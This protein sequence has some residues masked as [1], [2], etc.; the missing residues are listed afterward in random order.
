MRRARI[1]GSQTLQTTPHRRR[2][3][4]VMTAKT[5][6][7]VLGMHR[8]G[9]SSVAGALVL[10][11]GAPPKHLMPA[12]ADNPKGFWESSAIA[13]FNDRLL[14]LES[15]N[16]HD[17]RSIGGA[18]IKDKPHLLHEGVDLLGQEFGDA[19]TIV[20]KDP[21]ICRLFPFWRGLLEQAGYAIVI[22]SPVRPPWE[23]AASLASRN[24]MNHLHAFRLWMRH[25]LDAERASRGLQRSFI[26]WPA[27]LEN[28]RTDFAALAQASRLSLDLSDANAARIDA[29]LTSELHRQS[30]VAPAPAQV[31]RVYRLL[32][33]IAKHGDH[34]DTRQSLD[35]LRLAFNEGCDLF[36][37]APR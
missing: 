26:L 28:W 14:G 13:D 17:W 20:L 30:D 15:S 31:L 35:T 10:A 3:L 6:L 24:E 18:E 36:E 21:R 34:P 23:V 32:A 7:I 1:K 19:A 2:E 29:H 33:E 37:D 16:W 11:G 9:T 25:V 22:V 27:F 12:A 8:S 5:A 4:Q